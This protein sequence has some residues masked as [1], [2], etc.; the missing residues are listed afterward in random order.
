V[1]GRLD[2]NQFSLE[3]SGG[4]KRLKDRDDITWGCAKRVQCRDQIG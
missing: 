2:N 4:R 3:R 1:D